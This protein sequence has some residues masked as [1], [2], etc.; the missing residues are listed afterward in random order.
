MTGESCLTGGSIT[1]VMYS[2]FT[3]GGPRVGV[4]QSRLP[5]SL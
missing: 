5:S 3:I 2:A 1:A 4:G